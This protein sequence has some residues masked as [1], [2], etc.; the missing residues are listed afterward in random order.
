MRDLKLDGEEQPMSK[1]QIILGR[2]DVVQ[3][4]RLI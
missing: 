1:E 2:K 3:S 4:V